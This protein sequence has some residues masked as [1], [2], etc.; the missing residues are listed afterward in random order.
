MNMLW[1]LTAILAALLL[2]ATASAEVYTGVT[3]ALETV[4]VASETAGTLAALDAEVGQ[5]VSAG[6]PIMTLSSQRAFAAADGTVS[7]V[8]AGE[9][10]DVD[11]TVLEIAPIQRYTIHCI[12]TQAYQSVENTLVHAGETLYARCTQDGSHRAVGTVYDVD[13]STYK[14]LTTGGE[15]YL[16][17]TVYLYRGTDFT[18]VQRVGIGTVVATDPTAYEDSGKLARLCV[19]EGDLVERGQLLYEVDGGDVASPVSGIVTAIDVQPGESVV[20]DQIVA[21]VVPDGQVGV[22]VRVDETEAAR[23]QPGME[24][25]LSFA[26]VPE[27]TT[28]SG[29]VVDCSWMDADGTYLV[30]IRPEIDVGL[31]LGMSVTVWM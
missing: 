17:E 19:T 28:V 18:A 8:E 24:V 23:I 29:T 1:K 10:D 7:L 20:K 14:I 6:Q 2:C 12:V 4:N 30:R 26:S 5:R 27:G 9:G 11:G 25:R 15:L 13:G 16:G 22:Q 3:A 31:P 21:H